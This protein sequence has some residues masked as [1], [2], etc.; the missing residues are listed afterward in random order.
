MEETSPN[1]MVMALKSE[2]EENTIVITSKNKEI[3]ALND[4]NEALQINLDDLTNQLA[5]ERFANQTLSKSSG[6]W[7]ERV[8]V[9]KELAEVKTEEVQELQGIVTGLEIYWKRSITIAFG[10]VLFTMACKLFYWQL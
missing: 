2:L 10:R 5:D 1:A 9:F 4:S 3:E 8:K 7:E 6:K